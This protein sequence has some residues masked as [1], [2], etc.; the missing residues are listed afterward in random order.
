MLEFQCF[1]THLSFFVEDQDIQE[2]NRIDLFHHRVAKLASVTSMLHHT[3]AVVWWAHH[4]TRSSDDDTMSAASPSA[5]M[6]K[7]RYAS[8]ALSAFSN[9]TLLLDYT[10]SLQGPTLWQDHSSVPKEIRRSHRANYTRESQWKHRPYWYSSVEG[11][12]TMREE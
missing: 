4:W 5:K 7:W 3:S 11:R 2:W 10:W 1:S 8:L 9:A 6:M 12:L